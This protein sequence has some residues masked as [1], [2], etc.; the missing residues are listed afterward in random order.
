VNEAVSGALSLPEID[1][2]MPSASDELKVSTS[3]IPS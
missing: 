3:S 1:M 2:P